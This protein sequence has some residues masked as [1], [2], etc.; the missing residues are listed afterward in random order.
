MTDQRSVGVRLYALAILVGAHSEKHGLQRLFERRVAVASEGEAV[1]RFQVFELREVATH[2]R[3]FREIF[4]TH[5]VDAIP[6][7]NRQ[8]QRR[9]RFRKLLRWAILYEVGIEQQQFERV[10]V[11]K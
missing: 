3:R 9:L 6:N 2:Q 5:D 1:V 4:G 7:F 10:V 8:P 11:L